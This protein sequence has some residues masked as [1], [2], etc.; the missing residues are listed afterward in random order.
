ML[1]IFISSDQHGYSL[2]IDNF[3]A[4][5]CKKHIT[6]LVIKIVFPKI[7]VLSFLRFVSDF[8]NLLILANLKLH[9]L[10][11]FFPRFLEH[12]FTFECFVFL[13]RVL[14]SLRYLTTNNNKQFSLPAQRRTLIVVNFTG[15]TFA[16]ECKVYFL[17]MFAFV[18]CC[19][20]IHI[21]VLIL[22]MNMLQAF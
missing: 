22:Y 10:Y 12:A 14:I 16:F 7:A 11:N 18:F 21:Q 19:S 15:S 8:I 13:R 9:A 5:E 6:Y 2:I 3:T 17:F 1:I 4:K 20:P